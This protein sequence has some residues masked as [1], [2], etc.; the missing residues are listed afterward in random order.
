MHKGILVS[1]C[2]YSVLH[3]T[4]FSEFL[5]LAKSSNPELQNASVSVKQ[6]YMDKQQ[7]L[8]YKNPT[9]ELGVSRFEPDIG[10]SELGPNISISQPVRLFGIADDKEKYGNSKI[11]VLKSQEQ[12]SYAQFTYMIS[13]GY[14]KHI[15][16]SKELELSKESNIL[17]KKI[18]DI[19]T[20]MYESGVI[21]RGEYLQ[22]KVAYNTSKSA[23][24]ETN[25]QYKRNYYELLSSA[26]I[27]EEI[28]VDLNHIFDLKNDKS[29]NPEID[30][31]NKNVLQEQNKVAVDSNVI[32][33]MEL[34]AEYE[35][36]PDEDIYRIGLSIPL[37]VFNTN[38]EL[39]QIAKLEVQ[40]QN[41]LV[42]A[43]RKQVDFELGQLYHELTELDVLKDGYIKLVQEEEELLEMFE[44]SY[45][46]AKVN[47]LALQKIKNSLINTKRNLLKAEMLK[48]QNILKINYLQGA[49]NE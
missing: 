16:V 39:E 49:I 35:S 46:I 19:S 1:L 12:L 8:N 23:L 43:K 44:E 33:W 9:L 37:A 6:S 24:H 34:S 18:Y 48:Q 31:L 7:Q 10:T 42:N 28:E 26:N 5:E 32:E 36:E 13:L 14:L 27:T 47:L 30:F 38:K 2:V 20:A 41:T 17:A 4:N 45:K 11:D 25:F 29:L 22:T 15:A 40:K 21:S 3:A